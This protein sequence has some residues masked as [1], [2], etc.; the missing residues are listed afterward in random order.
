MGR[1]HRRCSTHPRSDTPSRKPA[2]AYPR[3]SIRCDRSDPAIG[4]AR[5]PCH[6]GRRRLRIVPRLTRLRADRAGTSA[7]G[8]CA[9]PDA[10]GTSHRRQSPAHGRPDGSDRPLTVVRR[11]G[12]GQPAGSIA[13]RSACHRV[14]RSTILSS[15][16]RCRSGSDS[17]WWN[18][19][20]SLQCRSAR[21][22]RSRDSA[23]GSVPG[24]AQRKTVPSSRRRDPA[25]AAGLTADRMGTAK[26]WNPRRC[27]L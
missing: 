12:R 11:S 13:G 10:P 25:A 4:G 7:L 23:F 2:A 20:D 21:Y 16:R 3:T 9:P 26:E 17:R 22:R 18:G 6:R 15:H 27:H 8:R 5:S 19:P 24:V 1:R 14:A